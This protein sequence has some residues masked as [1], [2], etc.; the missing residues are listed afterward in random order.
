M[1]KEKR[2]RESEPFFNCVLNQL[3]CGL[4]PAGCEAPA[5]DEEDDPDE[6]DRPALPPL[7]AADPLEPPLLPPELPRSP[8]E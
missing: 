6:D 1:Q 5:D 3:Q 2:R 7:D 4:P 8:P